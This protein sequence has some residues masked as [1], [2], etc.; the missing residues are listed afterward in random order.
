M[1]VYIRMCTRHLQS[2]TSDVSIL[3]MRSANNKILS[4]EDARI[5]DLSVL[6]PK[7][8]QSSKLD[9]RPSSH[10]KQSDTDYA[11]GFRSQ[12]AGDTGQKARHWR[13][14]VLSSTK[15]SQVGR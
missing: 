12:E 15:S 11:A 8:I 3:S 2:V 9:F 6:Q 4:E 1:G 10:S 13:N 14:L 7:R 5:I